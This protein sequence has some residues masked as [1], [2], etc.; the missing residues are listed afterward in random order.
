MNPKRLLGVGR[1][2]LQ[3]AEGAKFGAFLAARGLR[4]G[5][6][7][8]WP[9]D[10]EPLELPRHPRRSHTLFLALP[11]AGPTCP[12]RSKY[13]LVTYLH[14]PFFSTP[15]NAGIGSRCFLLLFFTFLSLIL[16][17]PSR[18]YPSAFPSLSTKLSKLG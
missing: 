1:P 9:A 2:T 7:S 3:R 4:C 10:T 13:G 11:I 18:S 6:R 5:N 17:I 8:P 14:C 16:L 12:F 15:I